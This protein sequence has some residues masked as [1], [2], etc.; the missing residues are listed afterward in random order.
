MS[1]LWTAIGQVLI[2]LIPEA[3]RE[4]RA[5]DRQKATDEAQEKAQRDA[6]EAKQRAKRSKP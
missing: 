6:F 3:L 5:S 2:A 4:K 1:S